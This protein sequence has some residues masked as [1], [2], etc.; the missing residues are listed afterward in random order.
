MNWFNVL[1]CILSIILIS[2]FIGNGINTLI[3]S[4]DVIV[5]VGSKV[6]NSTPPIVFLV[7]A[8]GLVLLMGR[9]LENFMKE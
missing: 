5:E 4:S 2:T 3:E 1:C 6:I 8:V 7:I 9:C